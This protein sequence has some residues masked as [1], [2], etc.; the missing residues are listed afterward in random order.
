M[1]NKLVLLFLFSSLTLSLK[2]QS[3]VEFEKFNQD[4]FI[5]ITD[6]AALPKLEYTRLKTY[7]AHIDEQ[8]WTSK[9]KESYKADLLE[10][11]AAE[12][13]EFQKRLGLIVD[14]YQIALR[15]GAEAEFLDFSYQANPDWKNRYQVSLNILYKE[16]G[17]QSV[18]RFDYD[19]YYNGE[20]LLFIGDRIEEVY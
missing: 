12:Y 7:K 9:K 14:R 15:N 17:M 16:E 8:D 10:K 18:V 11:Y 2:A 13:Q 4:L 1:R 6:S 3:E 19:L 5:L 20:T